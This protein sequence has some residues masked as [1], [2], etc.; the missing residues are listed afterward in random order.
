MVDLDVAD[1]RLPRG[2]AGVLS[3][4]ATDAEG[5]A[6]NPG[7]TTVGVTRA[8][9]S[10]LVP[11]ATATSGTEDNPR[12]L[13]LTPAQTATLDTLTVTWTDGSAAQ[14][15]TVV[16]IAGG[17]LFT[18]A[19][20][21]AFRRDAADMAKYPAADVALQRLKA[22]VECEWICDVA[23]VPRYRRVTV[24]G[25]GAE[26]L[27]L[28]DHEVRT[29]RSLSVDGIAWTQGQIDDL[30]FDD[31]VVARTSGV[32][33][34]SERII[35]GYEHGRR[36]PPEDLRQGVMLRCWEGL[37]S[38]FADIP[39]RTTRFRTQTSGTTYELD[40][41]TAYSTGNP[42]IDAAYERHSRRVKP[43]ADGTTDHA[44]A[45]RSLNFD[46]SIDSVFHG[47]IR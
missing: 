16:E 15:S 40:K 44:P 37:T 28:P 32:W 7:T 21:R 18:A 17:H 3:W 43:G 39:A 11:A 46:P 38:P 30:L 2:V 41:A 8:D 10:V 45:S 14:F 47:G 20:L 9:G 36:R 6:R 12:T 19:E 34:R 33:T 29:I 27:H 22:E 26:T 23:F 25:E 35:I 5:E 42:D 13:A 1:Q 24:A 4:Q 31:S